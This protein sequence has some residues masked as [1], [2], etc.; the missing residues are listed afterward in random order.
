MF[1]GLEKDYNFM[2]KI[3]DSMIPEYLLI[4]DKVLRQ[5]FV[6]EGIINH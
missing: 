5:K 6:M 1:K 2:R 3:F 4:Q